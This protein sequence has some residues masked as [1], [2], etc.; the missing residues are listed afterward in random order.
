MAGPATNSPTWTIDLSAFLSCP[1]PLQ[2]DQFAWAAKPIVQADLGRIGTSVQLDG[3]G[4]VSTAT[5]ALL[6]AALAAVDA[7][8]RVSGAD[9]ALT[10]FGQVAHQ[11]LAADCIEGGPHVA[12]SVLPD[13]ATPTYRRVRFSLTARTNSNLTVNAYALRTA[14]AAGRPPQGDPDRRP[15]GGGHGRAVRAGRPRP[16]P[17]RLPGG[18]VGPVVRVGPVVPG[19]PGRSTTWRPGTRS[20]PRSCPTRSR[21]T[22]GDGAA[23]DGRA[24]VAAE[25]DAQHRLVT[26]YRF[27]LTLS[28]A[29]AVDAG[30]V[31]ATLLAA[32][33]GAMPGGAVVTAESASYASVRG[34]RLRCEF[35]TLA[36]ADNNGLLGY[37]GQLVLTGDEPT[38]ET[39]TYPG[40]APVAVQRAAVQRAAVLP[41]LDQAGSAVGL[42]AF[43]IEPSPLWPDAAEPPVRRFAYD[44]PYTCRTEWAYR[45]VR[46]DGQ[47]VDVPTLLAGFA[48]PAK[49]S[50][51]GAAGG[52]GGSGAGGAGGTGTAGG[53]GSAG[54]DSGGGGGGVGVTV[55]GF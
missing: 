52:G 20:P 30:G 14:V 16:V 51:Y 39:I 15:P 34:R 43:V 24:T 28:A 48:R 55:I 37:A 25:R 7:A 40:A 44:D 27:E 53:G 19:R 54:G 33:T 8:A 50:F 12:F 17:R 32:V 36:A 41:L 11:V 29:Q 10:T 1:L 9:F 31:R 22:G 45:Q 23:V 46:T 26:R 21:P 47:A 35:E 5:P 49:P 18:D 38:Y 6:A 4:Y 2:V 3:E 13:R 42:G